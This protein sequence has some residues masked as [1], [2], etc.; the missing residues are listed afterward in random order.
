[1]RMIA[2]IEVQA[3]GLRIVGARP[4]GAARSADA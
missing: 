2:S 1:L 4:I 3:V